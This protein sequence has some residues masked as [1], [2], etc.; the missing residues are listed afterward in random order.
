MDQSST[1]IPEYSSP[2]LLLKIY[3]NP[4]NKSNEPS[5]LITHNPELKKEIL[6]NEPSIISLNIESKILF[7]TGNKTF[8]SPIEGHE[9]CKKRT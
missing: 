2:S 8:I 3:S 6:I 1:T 5:I 4:L 9:N 7:I